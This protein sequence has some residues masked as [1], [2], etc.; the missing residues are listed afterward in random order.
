[1]GA[2]FLTTAYLRVFLL[3]VVVCLFG[4][5][6]YGAPLAPEQFAPGSVRNLTATINPAETKKSG[7]GSSNG[8]QAQ[9]VS[10]EAQP[11]SDEKVELRLAWDAP[12]VDARGSELKELSGFR[13]FKLGVKER[14]LVSGT[15]ALD[16][17]EFVQVAEIK[18]TYTTERDMMR[19]AAR[20]KGEIG[21]GINV[22]EAKLHHEFSDK[23]LRKGWLYL[24][25]IVPINQDGIEGA[26]AQL[27]RVLRSSSS[28]TKPSDVLILSA[29]DAGI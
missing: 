6:R 26:P 21:R 2:S 12:L 23:M 27:V 3:L 17:S 8:V 7:V 16:E 10:D 15:A 19:K 13:L 11:V 29:S 18:S 24:F 5:G 20:E 25:K 14:D 28:E 1:M 22:D 4:C 9:P